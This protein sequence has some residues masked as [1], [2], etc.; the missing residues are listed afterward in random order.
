MRQAAA[1]GLAGFAVNWA[2]TGN[3]AQT[4]AENVY[5]RRLQAM[6]DAVHKVNSEGIPFTLWLSYKASAKILPTSAIL[7]DLSYFVSTYG[8]DSAFDHSLSPKP[9]VIWQGSDK[10]A[11]SVLQTVGG[12]Y[13]GAL[14]LV[15]DE[16]AWST[17]RAQYLDGDAYYWS[18]Q[19]PW[20]NPQSFGQLGA[21]AAAVRSSG[22][23]PDGSGKLWIAPAA[24]GFDAQ[25]LG[26]TSCV[27][28]RGGNTLRKLIE[29]N[30]ATSPNAWAIISWNE[31]AEG[32]YIDPMTRYG[33]QDLSVLS[34]M[35]R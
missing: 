6:V 35:I 33:E 21:L 18:S 10:Y 19:N 16:N 25:L 27:P 14:R 2:G 5:S 34:S 3:A 23:N 30:A 4:T 13:R 20:R 17:A 22:S 9:T 1:A 12:R 11:Q 26:R 32:T 24:P 29:G 31:I 15:G 7:G 28:R 8:H